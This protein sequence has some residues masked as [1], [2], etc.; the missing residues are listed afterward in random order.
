[1]EKGEKIKPLN[2]KYAKD[3]KL[4]DVILQSLQPCVVIEIL[5][6]KTSQKKVDLI[7]SNS[8]S[9]SSTKMDEV[10]KVWVV[11]CELFSNKTVD[12]IF[13]SIDKVEIPILSWS[14][15]ILQSIYSNGYTCLTSC[16]DESIKRN[17][18]PLPSDD[19]S[20]FYKLKREKAKDP[21]KHLIVQVVSFKENSKIYAIKE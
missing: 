13:Q 1:M 11:A 15:W 4:K 7:N 6:Q 5:A 9:K 18:I 20:L 3:L 19:D 21:N 12:R 2:Y 8:K 16:D 14:S 17:D 10:F